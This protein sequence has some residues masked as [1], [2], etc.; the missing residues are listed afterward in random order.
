LLGGIN[1]CRSVVL[2]LYFLS[3]QLG[4]F[5]GAYGGGLIYDAAGGGLYTLA[6]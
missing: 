6:C 2:G 5:V 4:S 1:A 3:H